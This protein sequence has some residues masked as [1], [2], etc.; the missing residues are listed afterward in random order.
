MG[1]QFSK[2]GVAVD[3]KAVDDPADAKTNGQENGHVKTNGDVSAKPDG[4]ATPVDGNGTPE[5][6]KEGETDAIEAAP[7]A[8]GEVVEGEAAKD[9]KKKKKFSLKN[10][11][12]FKGIS[13]R[14]TKKSS[15]EGKEEAASPTAED[16]PEENGHAAKETS[17]TEPVAEAKE[18]ATPAPEGEAAPAEEAPAEEAAAPAEVTTPAASETEPKTE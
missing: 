15:E 7:A 4:D 2:G 12:K 10:S 9:A 14:K 8:E 13:L 16:K 11:F 3:G 18:E 5:P 17:A 6:A 1:A